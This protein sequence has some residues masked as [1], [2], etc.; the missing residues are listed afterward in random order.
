MMVFIND[1]PCIADNGV[2]VRFARLVPD[3]NTEREAWVLLTHAERDRA[4]RL[5]QPTDRERYIRVRASVRRVL[6]MYLEV[7]PQDVTIIPGQAGKPAVAGHPTPNFPRFSVS[8][9]GPVAVMAMSTSHEVGTDVERV[10]GDI[11]W[12]QIARTFF[13]S[14][15]QEAIAAVPWAAQ[16]R[17]FFDCW[18]RKEAYL[19]G[20]GV[21]L[22]R[23]TT[24][25]S[26]P[27][28][29]NDGPIEDSAAAPGPFGRPW[30]VYGL[31]IE[32]GLAASVAADGQIG[33]TLLPWDPQLSP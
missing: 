32:P 24:N 18:V 15:E 11:G 19:K 33:L 2:H 1:G 13:S 4:N 10:R 21:G 26:V 7:A 8:H 27:V 3:P 22:R 17:A 6:A 28:L 23:A 25:F 14:A 12:R 20:L 29:A 31:D 30:H 16:R 9:S 5:R